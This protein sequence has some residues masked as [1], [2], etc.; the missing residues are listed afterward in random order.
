MVDNREL[1]F[2]ILDAA[3]VAAFGIPVLGIPLATMALVLRQIASLDGSAPNYMNTESLTSKINSA[4][5]DAFVRQHANNIAASYANYNLKMTSL[6]WPTDDYT[7]MPE[8]I[9]ETEVNNLYNALLAETN[10]QTPLLASIANLED[11]EYGK[12]FVPGLI[13][14]QAVRLQCEKV[15]TAIDTKRQGTIPASRV[16]SIIT[17]CDSYYASL[18]NVRM[19]AEAE[20]ISKAAS[21]LAGAQFAEARDRTF[22]LIYQ[23][24]PELA[25]RTLL[26][27]LKTKH[28]WQMVLSPPRRS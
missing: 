12:H 10:G 20:A 18:K 23:G 8:N 9:S 22:K 7:A 14:G 11:K 15:L 4:V 16:R 24:N 21:G 6:L 19:W 17:L 28:D 13:M 26:N 3:T 2:V 1:G 27:Y 25:D 5:T